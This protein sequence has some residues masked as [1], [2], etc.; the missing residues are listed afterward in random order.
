MALILSAQRNGP[1]GTVNEAFRRYA[2]YVD[3]NT[4]RFPPGAFELATSSWYFDA[5]DHRCPHDAWVE[6]LEI[7]E[8]GE[9]GRQDVRIVELRVTLLGAYHD[10]RI[11]L[12]YPKVYGYE[13]RFVG[14]DRGHRD[15]LYDEFRLS[16]AGHLV[17]EIEWAGPAETG[18]WL[19]DASDVEFI[20]TPF[21][22]EDTARA[23]PA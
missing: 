20:W 13:I 6:S 10:G 19:I 3:A 8:S 1:A 17:H 22:A 15:W 18:R 9:R 5:S 12:R 7:S 23:A 16:E 14:G 21:D 2:E 4:S 11:T